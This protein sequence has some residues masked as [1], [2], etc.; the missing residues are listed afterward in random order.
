MSAGHIAHHH[1]WAQIGLDL[2][3]VLW[4]LYSMT[5]ICGI[6]A[7]LMYGMIYR[8]NRGR[9]G[10]NMWLF[11]MGCIAR[12][13]RDSFS[14]TVLT[15]S[16]MISATCAISTRLYGSISRARFSSNSVLYNACRSYES[17]V[18]LSKSLAWRARVNC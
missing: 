5:V 3:Y 10:H 7:S 4:S 16:L 12:R 2:T 6:I 18:Q 9:V 14:S 15:G 11:G 17:T 8:C 1:K 13:T